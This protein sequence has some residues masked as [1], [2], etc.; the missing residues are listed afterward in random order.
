MACLGERTR[1]ACR[2]PRPR[3]IHAAT[4]GVPNA[5]GRPVCR[6]GRTARHA[7]RARSP[8]TPLCIPFVPLILKARIRLEISGVLNEEKHIFSRA[9]GRARVCVRACEHPHTRAPA[10]ARV[11]ARAPVFGP[12]LSGQEKRSDCRCLTNAVQLRSK[13][14][15]IFKRTLFV[16]PESGDGGKRMGAR[17]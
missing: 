9:S 1:L 15:A 16:E 10:P 17:E 2:I 3:G 11:R 6:A 5:C 7:R 14:S 4:Q 8:C 13:C 12:C